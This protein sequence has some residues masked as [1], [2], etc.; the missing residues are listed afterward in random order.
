MALVALDPRAGA[1][2]ARR[3]P[4]RGRRVRRAARG[5]RA[6][7]PAGAP[8]R[9]VLARVGRA[10]RAPDAQGPGGGRAAAARRPRGGP[11]HRRDRARDGWSGAPRPTSR[12][13]SASGSSPRAT[14]TPSSG[15]SPRGPTAPRPTTTPGDRVIE[16]GEP[17]V[18]DIGGTIGGYASDMTRTVWVT[19]GDPAR[20]PDDEFR[21]LY[22]VLQDAQAEATGRRPPGRAPASGSTRVARGIIDAAGYGRAVHPPHGPRHRARG[23]RGAVPRGRQRRAARARHRVQRGARH[24]P[25]GPLRRPDRGHRGLRRR[26]ARSCSTRRRGTC[27]SSRLSGWTRRTSPRRGVSSARSDGNPGRTDEPDMTD[28]PRWPTA[29]AV[30]ADEPAQPPRPSRQRPRA[31]PR[32]AYHAPAPER[33]AAPANGS[34][35]RAWRPGPPPSR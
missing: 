12:A 13:R 5:V 32:P 35:P 3:R 9:E 27:W 34:T 17:I 8:G 6:R 18:F 30:P 33:P 24:L 20:G 2:P 1:P 4:R 26:R 7:A 21:K 19:G 16:A 10:A 23:P 25:R 14:S 22:D 15:S 28:L 29:R 11:G 31:R